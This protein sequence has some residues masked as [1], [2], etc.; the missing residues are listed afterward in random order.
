MTNQSSNK[1]IPVPDA[2][3]KPYWDA[4]LQH[5]LKLPHCNRCGLYVFPP[6]PI[7]PN[8]LDAPMEWIKVS[9]RG[10]LYSFAVMHESYMRG[11]EAP[12]LIAQIELEEQSGLRLTV[13]LVDCDPLNA[14]IGM[15]VIVTFE[16]RGAGI[17]VPQ[18]RPIEQVI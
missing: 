4:A 1:P 9:G 17:S 16:D 3:T 6:K 7:C 18:F 11:F 15:P 12:Y 14:L 2:E 10:T 13:N 8:C 5:Q